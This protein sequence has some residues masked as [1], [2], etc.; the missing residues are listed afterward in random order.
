MSEPTLPTEADYV[1]IGESPNYNYDSICKAVHLVQRGARLIGC[2][3]D[4]TGPTEEGLVPSCRAL[5]A[6][7]EMATGQKAY[8][9]IL[10]EPDARHY[11]TLR[12]I[13]PA[14]DS[15]QKDDSNSLLNSSSS[16]SST[17]SAVYYNG[18]FDVPNPDGK[19]RIS[20]TAQV[21]IV[22]GEAKGALKEATYLWRNGM[23]WVHEV[24]DAG[25]RGIASIVATSRQS[26]S[27]LRYRLRA[28]RY[29]PAFQP[30]NAQYTTHD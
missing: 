2:N 29:S 28:D 18:L 12:A 15:I 8:F 22:L 24:E 23:L 26:E 3:S 11:G 19:L 27:A 20:M 1:V 13:E 30:R 7:I 14:P 21:F 10:G 9:I 5:V 16:S 17:S 6:P 25:L 4:L